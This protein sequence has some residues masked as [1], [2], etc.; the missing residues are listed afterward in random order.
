MRLVPPISS[1]HR[2]TVQFRHFK[3]IPFLHD[4]LLVWIAA[5]IAIVC[6]TKTRNARKT[7]LISSAYLVVFGLHALLLNRLH[8][9]CVSESGCSS[10]C[11]LHSKNDR[12]HTFNR[13]Q[14]YFQPLYADIRDITSELW[15][16]EILRT[17]NSRYQYKATLLTH[18]ETSADS[19]E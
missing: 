8:L 17:K 14:V 13:Q 18:L 7:F 11:Q 19:P 9:E 2:P 12:T 5:P 10:L 3:Y 15:T 16:L 4:L 6:K 1:S